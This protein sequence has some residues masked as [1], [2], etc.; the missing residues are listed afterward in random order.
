MSKDDVAAVEPDG[1]ASGS[2]GKGGRVEEGFLTVCSSAAPSPL[3][4]RRRANHEPSLPLLPLPSPPRPTDQSVL[5]RVMKN[6]DPLVLAPELAMDSV[7]GPVCISSKFSS[8]NVR[9]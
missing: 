4:S 6:W 3:V 8:G 9:P 1:W 2:D 5:A 7:P